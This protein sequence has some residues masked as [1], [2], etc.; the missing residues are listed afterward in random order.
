MRLLCV[1]AVVLLLLTVV[2]TG[3]ALAG[4]EKTLP[5]GRHLIALSVPDMECA[6]CIRSVQS[7]IK[8]VEGV[9]EVKI[10][11]MRRVVIVRFDPHLT[12]ARRIQGAI[13]KAGF[14]SQLVEPPAN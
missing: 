12:D 2:T 14:T 9:S 11:D 4:T 13:R 5:D 3:A 8:H 10:D 7:E 6:M 1:R